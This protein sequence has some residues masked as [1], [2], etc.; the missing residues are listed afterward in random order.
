M[1]HNLATDRLADLDA[2]FDVDTLVVAT[3]EEVRQ[4]VIALVNELARIRALSAGPLANVAE[5]ESVTP[6][7]ITIAGYNDNRHDVGVRF[8]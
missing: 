7:V 1:F 6:L 5:V 3:D 4:Q 8:T 2:D